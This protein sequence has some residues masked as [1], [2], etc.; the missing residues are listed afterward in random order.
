MAFL[1]EFSKFQLSYSKETKYLVLE[2][3][4]ILPTNL[5]TQPANVI[6]KQLLC[7]YYVHNVGKNVKENVNDY[8]KK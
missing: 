2:L 8:N 1:T 3:N 6:Y 7:I 4:S 5:L